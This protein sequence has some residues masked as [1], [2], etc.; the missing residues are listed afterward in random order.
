MKI[1]EVNK[2]YEYNCDGQKFG[3]YAVK[4]DGTPQVIVGN[5]NSVGI[6]AHMWNE[7]ATKCIHLLRDDVSSMFLEMI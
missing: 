1:E 3:A 7:P 5:G 6:V 4:I 2:I